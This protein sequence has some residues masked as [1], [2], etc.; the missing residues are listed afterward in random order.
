[1]KRLLLSAS[2][3]LCC[4]TPA[5]AQKKPNLDGEKIL[6]DF[7]RCAMRAAPR[8]TL[9]V[10]DT[11]PDGDGERSQI[12][13][14]LRKQGK[15]VNFGASLEGRQLAA[16]VSLGQTSLTQAVSELSGTQRQMTFPY[17]AVRGAI[18]ERAYLDTAG[19]PLMRSTFTASDTEPAGYAV[20]RCAVAQ[21]PASAD[22]LV[23]AKRL[24]STEREAARALSPALNGC[25]RG[26]GRVDISGTAIHGWAAE[27]LYKQGRPDATK[28]H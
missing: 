9:M 21:D 25:A 22:R 23:R 20:V 13:L 18:A 12:E 16:Q 8:E 6:A 14:L 28:G 24:S 17:R 1:M 15:C 3:A 10:L 2:L 19:R 27:A 11:A 4:A 7:A 26:K 5:L